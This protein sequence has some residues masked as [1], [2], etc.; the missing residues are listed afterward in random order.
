M[1]AK[2]QEQ[3]CGCKPKIGNSSSEYLFERVSLV[4]TYQCN[5]RCRFCYAKRMILTPKK[6]MDF[7]IF[8]KLVDLLSEVGTDGIDLIGGEPT[9]H[10][11]LLKMVRYVRGKGIACFLITNGRI[12][13]NRKRLEEIVNE[14]VNFITV[15]VNVRNE[16]DAANLL[17]TKAAYNE[18]IQALKNGRLLKDKVNMC[19][20]IVINKVDLD[21]YTELFDMLCE[22]G[23]NGF[24]VGINNGT[25]YQEG[26]DVIGHKDGV[27]M[28]E[29]LAKEAQ[30]RNLDVKFLCKMPLCLFKKP[31]VDRYLEIDRI[32]SSCRVYMKQYISIEPDGAILPCTYFAGYGI[33][34]MF[35]FYDKRL[36]RFNKEK[37]LGSWLKGKYARFRRSAFKYRAAKCIGC[38]Y[39]PSKCVGG[40]MLSYI[41]KDPEKIISGFRN[42][43]DHAKG[44]D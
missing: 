18:M 19:V 2:K 27:K 14:G 21:Y 16:K 39:F 26:N 3:K 4:T 20:H 29:I 11:D 37:F 13:A 28:I 8:T 38:E 6:S 15:S 30:K 40:C 23:Y 43:T 41:D 36:Q 1:T 10:Q 24:S 7:E 31:F 22:L 25:V 35:E 12:F 5:N 32:N 33:G 34:N 44:S 17:G 9:L 42:Q